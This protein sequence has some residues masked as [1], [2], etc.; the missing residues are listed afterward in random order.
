M[1][2]KNTVMKKIRLT[3]INNENVIHPSE[4]L[5][6]VNSFTNLM[7]LLENFEK[8]NNEYLSRQ[9]LRNQEPDLVKFFELRLYESRHRIYGNQERNSVMIESMSKK[10]PYWI[11]LVLNV[12][13][14][15]LDILHLVIEAH[16]NETEDK[17]ISILSKFEWF[18]SKTSKEQRAIVRNFIRS[19]TFILRF[20]R[21]SFKNDD[22]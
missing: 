21:I 3:S 13:P 18:D 5:S 9:R 7:N 22:E 8:I 6:P 4:L 10:S 14:Y 16:E 1:I 15:V 2:N 12:S 17:L 19:F 20:V 11:D